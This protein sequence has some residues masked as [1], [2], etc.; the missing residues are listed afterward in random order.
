MRPCRPVPPLEI[1]STTGG[2]LIFVS[3]EDV[4]SAAQ[5]VQ[6]WREG[7]SHCGLAIDYRIFSI[8]AHDFHSSDDITPSKDSR[9]YW[10]P[11]MRLVLLSAAEWIENISVKNDIVAVLVGIEA[12]VAFRHP[13]NVRGKGLIP[14]IA[15]DAQS[16]IQLPHPLV[17]GVDT[18]SKESDEGF[19]I[20]A[21]GG[22][23][24]EARTLIRKVLA[25][26]SSAYSDLGTVSSLHEYVHRHAE[27]VAADTS[28]S[29]FDFNPETQ[30]SVAV[31]R[32]PMFVPQE[33]A[34]R[35]SEESLRTDED[36]WKV[37]S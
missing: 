21:F 27:T 13:G 5:I 34:M 33:E 28:G 3:E 32:L 31:S 25:S 15:L 7:C 2:I 26:S 18:T 24:S 20:R 36:I 6:G 23:A 8:A 14:E 1:S 30:D 35:W 29:F 11:A 17:F 22:L 37:M 4:F 19:D 9:A 10:E 12:L 16:L